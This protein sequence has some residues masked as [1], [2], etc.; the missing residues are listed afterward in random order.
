MLVTEEVGK[1]RKKYPDCKDPK[2]AARF[3]TLDEYMVLS[4]RMISKFA[5]ANLRSYMLASEDA[6]DFVA[7]KIMKGDWCYEDEKTK[8]T[9]YR[10]YCAQ[11]A[12]D[13]YIKIS[14]KKKAT[15]SL[16]AVDDD[17]TPL[18]EVVDD[19]SLNPLA[20]MIEEEEHKNLRHSLLVAIEAL[21]S[22]QRDCVRMHYMEGVADAEIARRLNIT[23]QAVQ[24]KIK[25]GLEIMRGTLDV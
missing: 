9:T 21:P 19:Q 18:N 14:M 20:Q 5:P 11:K 25:R 22:S 8:L 1:Q 13:Y 16:D 6:I 12:I 4:R 7:H 15:L 2:V 10:G 17:D 24:G 23:R 3:L